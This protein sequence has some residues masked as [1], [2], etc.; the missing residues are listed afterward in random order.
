MKSLENI[1][2]VFKIIDQPKHLH[3]SVV[4]VN[5]DKEEF[6]LDQKV[7]DNLCALSDHSDIM[8]MFL[9]N[10]NYGIRINKFASLYQACGWTVTGASLGHSLIK[11]L[12]YIRTVFE[13]HLIF[14]IWNLEDLKGE[15]IKGVITRLE[16]P[17]IG[18]FRKPIFEPLRLGP[19]E[20][21]QY[22]SGEPEVKVESGGGF[23]GNLFLGEAIKV[24]EEPID[25]RY[26]IWTS[27]SREMIIPRSYLNNLLDI[28]KGYPW[29]DEFLESFSEPDIKV[30][31]INLIKRVGLDYLEESVEKI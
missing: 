21:Y 17:D 8:F 2:G 15:S 7:H 29:I 20:L 6:P 24:E 26:M 31:L 1:E 11:T 4:L 23:W 27:K 19:T 28:I 25:C 9:G 3:A 30:P 22:Y 18:T 12:T 16:S 5:L 13:K 14:E 10:R